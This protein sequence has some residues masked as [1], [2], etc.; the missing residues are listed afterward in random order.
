MTISIINIKGSQVMDKQLPEVGLVVCSICRKEVPITAA[1]TPE[2]VDY[3]V[4]FCGLDCYAEWQRGQ[5][6]EENKQK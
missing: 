4:N 1:K 3:V 6:Q 2:S 5:P